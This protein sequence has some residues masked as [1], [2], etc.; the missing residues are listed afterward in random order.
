M[1]KIKYD[2]AMVRAQKIKISAAFGELGE[3]YYKAHKDDYEE[4]FAEPIAKIKAAEDVIYQ[5]KVE[6]LK[7]NG[8]MLCPHCGEEILD[9]SRFCNFCGKP[10]EPC[11]AEESAPEPESGEEDAPPQEATE[12]EEAKAEE[13]DGQDEAPEADETPDSAA[14]KCPGCGNVLGEYDVFCEE[15]GMRVQEPAP[16]APA[17][18]EKKCPLCG[19]TTTDDDVF[20]CVECGAKLQ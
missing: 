17:V 11:P 15:C 13:T 14:R 7:R 6:V 1:L 2:E 18:K 5:H 19:F 8:L 10:V 16:E 4:A 3:L 9:V 12:P 20:F